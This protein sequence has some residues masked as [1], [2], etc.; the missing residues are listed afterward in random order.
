MDILVA[1]AAVGS[2]LKSPGLSKEILIYG[3]EPLLE[4]AL[5]KKI[6]LF[7]KKEAQKN[8]KELVVSVA[9]NGILLDSEKLLF[10]KKNEVKI[11]ISIDGDKKTH[12]PNRLQH[13]SIEYEKILKNLKLALSVMSPG[14]VSALVAVMPANAKKLYANLI[15]LQK[16][17]IE[18]F[19]LEPIQGQGYHWSAKAKAEFEKN[20][21]NFIQHIF[22][23]TRQGKFIFLGSVTRFLIQN[24]SKRET[25]LFC[26]NMEVSPAGD[27][28][29]SP[30][31]I[32][33]ERPEDFVVGNF[34]KGFKKDYETC[35]YDKHSWQ[36]RHCWKTYNGKAVFAGAEI[37]Q[38]RNRMSEIFAAILLDLAKKEKPFAAY[39]NKAQERIFE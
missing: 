15:Y 2:L 24:K 6:S 30:F 21:K 39:V 28:F 36:C 20:L 5:V 11:S 35:A 25:C 7:A 26:E 27:I 13:N 34:Q 4:F 8:K 33:A 1:K 38:L 22:K 3:G 12:A 37:V 31:L 14:Q 10:F 29:L 9:T 18:N 32:D 19:N 17:G 23:S 16:I